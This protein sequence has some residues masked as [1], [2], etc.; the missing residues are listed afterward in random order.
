MIEPITIH[1]IDYINET[2]PSTFSHET[3]DDV[4]PP[5]VATPALCERNVFMIS[6]SDMAVVQ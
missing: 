6:F 2:L 4:F 5:I 3:M 1:G